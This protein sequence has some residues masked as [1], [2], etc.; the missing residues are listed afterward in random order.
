MVRLQQ[1]EK[2]NGGAMSSVGGYFTCLKNVCMHTPAEMED[3]LG[4]EKGAF[5]SGVSIWKFKELPKPDQFEFRGH[6]QTPQG[7]RFDGI[8]LTRSDQKRP[9]FLDKDGKPAKYPPGLAVEQ[10]EVAENF[11]LP[12]IEIKKVPFGAVFKDCV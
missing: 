9:V 5:S 4:F 3:I 1:L 7:K 10:W 8:V 6:T 11:R 2:D 12:A